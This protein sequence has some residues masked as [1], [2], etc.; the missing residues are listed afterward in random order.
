MSYDDQTMLAIAQYEQELYGS[1]SMFT[2]NHINTENFPDEKQFHYRYPQDHGVNNSIQSNPVHVQSKPTYVNINLNPPSILGSNVSWRPSVTSPEEFNFL[3]SQKSSSEII[4]DLVSSPKAV[5][6]SG[7][8]AETSIY[9]RKLRS[10][11]SD[12]TTRDERELQ[13]KFKARKPPSSRPTSAIS[14]P[15]AQA[16]RIKQRQEELLKSV[17]PFTFHYSERKRTQADTNAAESTKTDSSTSAP[18][19]PLVGGPVWT[20]KHQYR[21]HKHAPFGSTMDRKQA[22]TAKVTDTAGTKVADDTADAAA[23]ADTSTSASTNTSNTNTNTSPASTTPYVP[24]MHKL[25]RVPVSSLEK[26]LPDMKLKDKERELERKQR[27]SELLSKAQL[28]GSMADREKKR[29]LKKSVGST[30][31]A[32]MRAEMAA[33]DAQLGGDGQDILLTTINSE[34]KKTIQEE[35]LKKINMERGWGRG[36]KLDPHDIVESGVFTKYNGDGRANH[37]PVIKT[38]IPDFNKLREEWDEKLEKSRVSVPTVVPAPFSVADKPSHMSEEKREK[39]RQQLQ[40]QKT[41]ELQKQK[42]TIKNKLVKPGYVRKPELL[43]QMRERRAKARQELLDR[44]AEEARQRQEKALFEKSIRERLWSAVKAREGTNEGPGSSNSNPT[45]AS[46]GND[47]NARVGRERSRS[48]S[49]SRSRYD[50]SNAG[51]VRSRSRSWVRAK[52]DMLERVKQRPLLIEEDE[53]TA[54][55]ERERRAL[56]LMMENLKSQGFTDWPRWFTPE[57]MEIMELE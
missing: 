43:D 8:S 40:E 12:V 10:Y 7:S 42:Y 14:D 57:E 32:V 49:A 26:R 28:P 27:A 52:K 9:R 3:T 48:R 25:G 30:R 55:A 35:K 38:E 50:S 41:Q 56:L 13:Q 44:E 16:E 53:V 18:A 37:K 24:P 19:E 11:L 2:L 4:K 51:S 54:G 17:T 5:D 6:S 29:K 15:A 45:G 22:V 39:L 21:S 34:S 1:P 36:H 46:S 23:T 31:D 33:L 20:D 47:R